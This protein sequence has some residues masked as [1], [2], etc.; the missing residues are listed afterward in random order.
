MAPYKSFW[1]LPGD[2]VY[3]QEDLNSAAQ[4]VLE[5]LTG[6]REVFMQQIKTF[7]KVD[8]HPLGRVITVAYNAL[9]RVENYEPRAA[10]W[11]DNVQWHTLSELGDLAFDHNDILAKGVEKLKVRVRNQPLGFEL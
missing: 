11:A 7:G 1:A 3:P 8:R 10:F 9:I 4:R 6:I 2:L 5:N